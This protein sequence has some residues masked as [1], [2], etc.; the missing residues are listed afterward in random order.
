MPNQTSYTQDSINQTKYDQGDRWG[1]YKYGGLN[2]IRLS[3][4][5]NVSGQRYKYG[6][7]NP[8]DT[9]SSYTQDS[10]NQSSYTGDS[11]NQTS[12]N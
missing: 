11:I 9:H 1:R 4:G 2:G 10:I 3:Y 8:K 5:G 12:W 6:G 7:R